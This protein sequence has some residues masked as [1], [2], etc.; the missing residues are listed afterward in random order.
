MRLVASSTKNA[1]KKIVIRNIKNS[2]N[3]KISKADN[4]INSVFEKNILNKDIIE[5]K[6]TKKLKVEIEKTKK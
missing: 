6:R 5:V 1:D 3:R 4:G 2:Y